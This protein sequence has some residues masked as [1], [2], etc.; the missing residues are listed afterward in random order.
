LLLNVVF[1]FLMAM[2]PLIM[3]AKEDMIII[4]GWTNSRSSIN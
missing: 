3:G 2:V 1:L 4:G